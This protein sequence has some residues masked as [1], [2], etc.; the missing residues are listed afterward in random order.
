MPFF[1]EE[2]RTTLKNA[3]NQ[4]E[5]DKQESRL[6]ARL[7][8]GQVIGEDIYGRVKL[9]PSSEARIDSSK[10]WMHTTF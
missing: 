5:L 2:A 6:L 7:M 9:F 10:D 4:K 8:E 1:G 3:M